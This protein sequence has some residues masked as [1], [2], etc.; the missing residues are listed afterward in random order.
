M[1]DRDS[2]DPV[3]VHAVEGV[4]ARAVVQVT[5]YSSKEEVEVIH[6][7]SHPA[8]AGRGYLT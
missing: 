5:N 8:L 3:L 4:E 1:T 6:L 2:T 7:V